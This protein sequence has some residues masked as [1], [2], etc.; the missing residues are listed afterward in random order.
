LGPTQKS[1]LFKPEI[2]R[3][4]DAVTIQIPDDVTRELESLA[5]VQKK[6]VEEVAVESL[7]L[8]FSDSDSPAA[9]LRLLQNLPHPRPEAVD[10]MEA[11]ILA[12]QLPVTDRG[13]FDPTLSQ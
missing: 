9:L 2:I 12:A 8:L 3:Q 4:R 10:D 13:R 7:R 1:I 6:T 11:A 5:S